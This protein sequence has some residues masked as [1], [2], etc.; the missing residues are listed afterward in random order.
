MLD[1]PSRAPTLGESGHRRPIRRGGARES[2]T[3]TFNSNSPWHGTLP[4]AFTFVTACGT[5]STSM[6]VKSNPFVECGRWKL[7]ASTSARWANTTSV[8]AS[9]SD[10]RID[11]ICE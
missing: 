8:V 1:D 10:E 11:G 4:T 3:T 7:C 5:A 9:S 6:P 2:G